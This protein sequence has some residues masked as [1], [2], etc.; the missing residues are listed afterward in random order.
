[1]ELE[2]IDSSK[3]A[4]EIKVGCCTSDVWFVDPMDVS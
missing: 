4:K 1:M 2:V 3:E